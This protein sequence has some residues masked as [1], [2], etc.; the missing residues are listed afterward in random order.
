MKQIDLNFSKHNFIFLGICL[1]GLVF[2]FLISLK[3]MYTQD[4]QL[5]KDIPVLKAKIAQQ[6]QLQNLV[7][8][9]DQKLS[10]IQSES[11]LPSVLLVPKPQDKTNQ[12]IPEIKKLARNTDTTI[13]SIEPLLNDNGKDWQN[14]TIQ[15]QMQGS[16]SNIKSF[17]FG[18]LSLPYLKGINEIE[19]NSDD[20]TLNLRLTYSV[21]LA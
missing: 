10:S 6:Q 8:M 7:A 14:L 21:I 1:T 9:I 20:N 2:L 13:I 3:P 5:K 18:L 17:L 15:S 4:K 12:I 11:K 19:I 16:F